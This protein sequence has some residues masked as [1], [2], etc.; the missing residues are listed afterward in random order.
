MHAQTCEEVP[1][2]QLCD[3]LGISSNLDLYA[4]ATARLNSGQHVTRSREQHCATPEAQPNLQNLNVCQCKQQGPGH[5]CQCQHG[6][7]RLQPACIDGQ[8]AQ[9]GNLMICLLRQDF[10]KLSLGSII[11]P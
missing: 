6:A 7:V 11:L 3:V 9:V 4:D 10:S 2:Q 5:A 1:G 8:S